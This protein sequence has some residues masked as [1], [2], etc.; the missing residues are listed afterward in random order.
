M[1]KMII[2]LAACIAG[3]SPQF[4]LVQTMQSPAGLPYAVEKAGDVTVTIEPFTHDTWSRLADNPNFIDRSKS[5]RLP[6]IPFFLVIIENNSVHPVT[7]KEIAV[8]YEDTRTVM[9]SIDAVKRL[10]SSPAYEFINVDGLLSPQRLLAY[11]GKTEKIDFAEDVIP[12]NLPFIPAGDTHYRV[13]ACSWIPVHI[14]DMSIEVALKQHEIEKTV[15]GTFVRKEFRTK[16]H[17][18]IQHPHP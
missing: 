16:G 15:V 3:C 9:L 17:H 6:K 4:G 18:F 5:G 7:V 14:R 11:R 13:T 1:N 10:L 2:V 12:V 8:V